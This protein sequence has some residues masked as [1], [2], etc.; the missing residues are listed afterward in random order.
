M[1]LPPLMKKGTASKSVKSKSTK[2]GKGVATEA[3]DLDLILSLI[4]KTFL[5]LAT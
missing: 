5:L 2:K 1:N 4:G 3:S